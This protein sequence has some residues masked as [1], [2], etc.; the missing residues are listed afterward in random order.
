MSENTVPPSMF[1]LKTLTIVLVVTLTAVKKPTFSAV[2]LL[3]GEEGNYIGVEID[4]GRGRQGR[5]RAER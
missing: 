2:G 3:V 4:P 1:P 5:E